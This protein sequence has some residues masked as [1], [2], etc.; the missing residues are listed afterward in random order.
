MTLHHAARSHRRICQTPKP[1]WKQKC[2]WSQRKFATILLR[3]TNFFENTLEKCPPE[4]TGIDVE[5][6]LASYSWCLRSNLQHRTRR[7]PP[8]AMRRRTFVQRRESSRRWPTT[9]TPTA[10]SVP[11]WGPGSSAERWPYWCSQWVILFAECGPASGGIEPW[12]AEAVWNRIEWVGK[13]RIPSEGAL[14]VS[15]VPTQLDRGDYLG[16]FTTVLG[17]LSWVEV[18]SNKG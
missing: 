9:T 7:S 13:G 16:K 18:K 2:K 14:S 11:V 5:V 6:C 10:K 3:A 1:K 15:T 17:D 8:V 12:E 4:T